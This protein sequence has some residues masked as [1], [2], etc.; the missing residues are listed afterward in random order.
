MGFHHDPGGPSRRSDAL[1][2][3][4]DHVVAKGRELGQWLG[5]PDL[6]DSQARKLYRFNDLAPEVANMSDPLGSPVNKLISRY[7]RRTLAEAYLRATAGGEY[8]I[9]E[10]RNHSELI[11]ALARYM[12]VDP[13]WRGKATMLGNH[14]DG[15]SLSDAQWRDVGRSL[16]EDG[17]VMNTLRAQWN[18][19]GIVRGYLDAMREGFEPVVHR[20][21]PTDL[22]AGLGH[23]LSSRME[24]RG[25]E[26]AA[27]FGMHNLTHAQ[28]QLVGRFSAMAGPPFTFKF[29]ED[30]LGRFVDKWPDNIRIE[31]YLRATVERF[32]PVTTATTP[33]ALAAGMERYLALDETYW[34]GRRIAHNAGLFRLSYDQ[35]RHVH[36]VS[37]L[38]RDARRA[39]MAEERVKR[40]LGGQRGVLDTVVR[41]LDQGD[42]RT[43]RALSIKDPNGLAD[44]LV[45]FAESTGLHLNEGRQ[46]AAEA[47][48]HGLT[49]LETR[50]IGRLNMRIG[51]NERIGVA[52]ATE[53][54]RLVLE[55]GL[56]RTLEAYL[57]LERKEA[58]TPHSIMSGIPD[59]GSETTW[60]HRI[61]G[62]G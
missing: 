31:A 51:F 50:A 30:P 36:E 49:D 9:L 28:A 55:R 43:H 20:R 45:D 59:R 60:T 34:S 12:D 39:D 33:D 46:L 32:D 15:T 1:Q 19:G 24:R 61:A 2:D 22:T 52:P 27:D 14:L 58:H 4:N 7:G 26:L 3:L 18:D 10:A 8:L 29:L 40:A 47:G 17:P 13:L 41:A 25:F 62:C 57:D 42:A 56:R 54:H 5:L 44:A 53:M 23:Y 37:E 21:T 11:P 16:P 35:A 38:F 48:I 6:T